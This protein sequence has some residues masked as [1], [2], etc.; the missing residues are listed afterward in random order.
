MIVISKDTYQ[1]LTDEEILEEVNRDRSEDWQDYTLDDLKKSRKEVIQWIDTEYYIVIDNMS[2]QK[3]LKEY[4]KHVQTLVDKSQDVSRFLCNALDTLSIPNRDK[5]IIQSEI[6]N[7]LQDSS[8][9]FYTVLIKNTH[10]YA[11]QFFEK[12]PEYEEILSREFT[13]DV[14]ELRIRITNQFRLFF[15]D[16]MIDKYKKHHDTSFIESMINKIKKLGN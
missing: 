4:K 14:H 7:V 5:E 16:K 10:K 12:N 13:E 3:S 9:S 15:I 6:N 11:K 8:I 1:E 2:I